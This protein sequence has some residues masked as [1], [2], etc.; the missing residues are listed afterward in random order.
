MLPAMRVWLVTLL[1]VLL[2]SSCKKSPMGR[3]EEIRDELERDSP[4][5]SDALAK[6]GDRAKCA[7]DV[8]TSIGGT[9]D[10]KKPD[11]ISAAAVAVV[12]ARDRHATDAGS[13]DVWLAAMRKAKG[14]GADAL[15]LATALAMK[16][17]VD[18]H[19]HRV[20]TDEGARAFMADVAASIPGACKTYDA[21]GA[22]AD[23]NT[24]PPVDSPDHSACV[25][26]DLGRKDGPGGAYGQGIFRAAAGARALW[27]EALAALH[28]G[29]AQ[30]DPSAKDALSRRLAALDEGTPKIALKV[31]E[32][33]AGNAWGQM[34]E[35]HQTPLGGDAGAPKRP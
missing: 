30:T 9:F 2:A 15:R 3:V 27:T 10:D 18:K 4:R 35:Q 13:P 23:P 19:A 8:A 21:L 12:V 28:E 7:K 29:E 22:G 1:A 31:V 17:A 5:F 25:Q 20:D 6:C 33:P 34:V 24:M 16:S 14:P 11:Q 26:R 32:A